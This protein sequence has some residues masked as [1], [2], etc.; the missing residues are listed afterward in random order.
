MSPC[1]QTSELVTQRRSTITQLL[2]TLGDW[3]FLPGKVNKPPASNYLKPVHVSA[4]VFSL[5]PIRVKIGPE[6]IECASF[7]PV[8][9]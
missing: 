7:V 5:L 8:T 1:L 2:A 4:V 3:A 6:N 9:N